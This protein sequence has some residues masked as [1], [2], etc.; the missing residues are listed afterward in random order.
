[1]TVIRIAF[2]ELH[3]PHGLTW[4][5]VV[6]DQQLTTRAIARPSD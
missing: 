3:I 5:S 2:Q 1:M 6:R 4:A